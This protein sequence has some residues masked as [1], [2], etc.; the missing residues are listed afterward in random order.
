MVVVVLAVAVA[1][2]TLGRSGCTPSV[3]GAVAESEASSGWTGVA[4]LRAGKC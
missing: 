2:L 1:G 4:N 3:T